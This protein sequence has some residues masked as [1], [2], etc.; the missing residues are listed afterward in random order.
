MKWFDNEFMVMLGLDGINQTLNKRKNE[1]EEELIRVQEQLALMTEKFK[2]CKE[3]LDRE[4]RK[5]EMLTIEKNMLKEIILN[6][7]K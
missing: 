7:R 5:N 1:T 6:S 2:Q 4:R 3:V